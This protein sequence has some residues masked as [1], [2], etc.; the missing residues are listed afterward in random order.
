[1]GWY[2]NEGTLFYNLD[3]DD[4]EGQIPNEDNAVDQLLKVLASGSDFSFSSPI[5]LVDRRSF[6]FSRRT[7]PAGSVIVSITG[8]EVRST[9][10][11]GPK[12][13]KRMA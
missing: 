1:M 12:A 5:G 4:E 9:D 11:Y 3:F 13:E 8:V 10:D 6:W 7:D 2:L